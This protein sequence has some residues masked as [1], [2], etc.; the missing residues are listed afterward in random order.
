MKNNKLRDSKYKVLSYHNHIKK[1]YI[2][3]ESGY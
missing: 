3:V 1:E 2:N